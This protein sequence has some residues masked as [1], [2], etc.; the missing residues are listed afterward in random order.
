VPVR[1]WVLSLP[2][3]LSPYLPHDRELIGAIL[4]VL[5]RAIET[6]LRRT[7]PAQRLTPASAPSPVCTA[8]APP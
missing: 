7:S 6:R 1:Q 8:S 3:R 2:K 4:R 5:L